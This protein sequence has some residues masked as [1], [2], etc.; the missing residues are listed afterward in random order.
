MYPRR[1]ASQSRLPLQFLVVAQ[2]ALFRVILGVLYP[3]PFTECGRSTRI[4][5]VVDLDRRVER[6]AMPE[7]IEQ[8]VFYKNFD[9]YKAGKAA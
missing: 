9:D 4:I 6:I 1:A 7:E 8:G 5:R 2:T 3:S